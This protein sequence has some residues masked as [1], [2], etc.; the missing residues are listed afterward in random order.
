MLAGQIMSPMF[1]LSK[2]LPKLYRSFSKLNHSRINSHT[3]SARPVSGSLLKSSLKYFQPKI[4]L[5]P[6][7][8]LFSA[9]SF[10][11]SS[12]KLETSEKSF[13]G[14]ESPRDLQ[15]YKGPLTK[16]VKILNLTSTSSI[17]VVGASA[18]W[19]LGI[20]G[21]ES[22]LS[23]VV[24]IGLITTVTALIGSSSAFVNWAFKSYVTD[25]NL[26]NQRDLDSL[27]SLN[28]EVSE[29]TSETKSG[30][31][32][33]QIKRTQT[34]LQK[35]LILLFGTL[36]FIGRDR[37]VAVRLNTLS[38]IADTPLRTWIA[39]SDTE[40]SSDELS[41]IESVLK[42][43]NIGLKRFSQGRKGVSYFAHLDMELSPEMKS[44]TEII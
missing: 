32:L 21:V 5:I 27:S 34:Q 29:Q 26:L 40:L 36:D 16:V 1:P 19:F 15:I 42:L 24:R 44:L 2:N 7:S 37:V 14:N 33:D 3:L 12:N 30:S 38:P 6:S 20:F 39:N 17:I 23:L 43:K 9:D 8:K 13:G 11:S 35:S 25:I 31:N 28:P 41:E 10:K 4:F 22:S 18:P